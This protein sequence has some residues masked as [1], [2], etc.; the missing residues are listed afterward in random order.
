MREIFTVFDLRNMSTLTVISRSF[1]YSITYYIAS[2][3]ST[4]KPL[5]EKFFN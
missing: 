1:F 4:A 5:K 3:M 2:D